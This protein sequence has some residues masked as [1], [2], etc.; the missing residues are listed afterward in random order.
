[1]LCRE[2]L[3]IQIVERR[4]NSECKL[5]CYLNPWITHWAL[6]LVN[7]IREPHEAKKKYFDLGGYR[8]H[9]LRIRSTVTPPTEL[10][11]RTEK[12]GDDL[13]GKSRRREK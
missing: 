6:A 10:Q 9:D 4:I 11:G 12:V 13:D 5:K 3:G 1:M 8:T 7:G 2:A